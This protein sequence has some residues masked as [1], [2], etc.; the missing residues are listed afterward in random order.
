VLQ[1]APS[2][3]DSLIVRAYQRDPAQ[4]T[5]TFEPGFTVNAGTRVMEL[6]ERDD[7]PESGRCDE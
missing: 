7:L 3:D 4:T 2:P 1:A 6:L 5:W